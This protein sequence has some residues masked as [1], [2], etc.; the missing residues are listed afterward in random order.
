MKKRTIS[1]PID[2]NYEY[3]TY[4]EYGGGPICLEAADPVIVTFEGEY[5]LFSSVTNGYWVSPDL[6]S[7]EFIPCNNEK[8]PNIN[9]YAPALMVMDGAI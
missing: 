6:A 4:D 8:L 1:N 9:N 7:W 2:V 3:R 5:Y